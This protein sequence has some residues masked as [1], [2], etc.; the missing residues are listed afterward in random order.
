MSANVTTFPCWGVELS[1]P[2]EDVLELATQF[3]EARPDECWVLVGEHAAVSDRQLWTAWFVLGSNHRNG[4]MRSNGLDG[5]FIR[6]LAGTHQVKV[7]FQRAGIAK[8]DNACWLI[9]LPKWAE[10]TGEAPPQAYPDLEQVELAETASRLMNV[11]KGTLRTHRPH[12][13]E[14]TIERLC[15]D[16]IAEDWVSI[17]RASLAHLAL[18]DL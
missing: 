9:H 2:V 10:E 1:S 18:A 7:G 11:L 17:E 15:L 4:T 8:G 5:E 3:I 16:T 6:L 13:S 12:P 14:N